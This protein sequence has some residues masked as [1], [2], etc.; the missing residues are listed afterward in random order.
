MTQVLVCS[1]LHLGHK[2]IHNLRKEVASCADNTAR[3]VNDW[4][5]VVTKRDRVYIL[6]DAAFDDEGLRVL[7]DLPGEKILV[8]GNHDEYS[9]RMYAYTFKDVVGFIK[10]KR[11][12]LSHCPIHP[13]ELRGRVNIH[14]HV[15]YANITDMNGECDQRYFN[16]C[17]ENTWKLFGTCVVPFTFVDTAIKM[18]RFGAPQHN[19]YI[20]KL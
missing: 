17:P 4:V 1:D 9:L 2:N 6:G 15:H 16:V 14:G 11:Y 20:E 10:Y 13:D 7:H 12:W 8:R 3:I 19:D 5:S 18:G